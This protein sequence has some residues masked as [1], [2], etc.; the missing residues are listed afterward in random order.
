MATDRIDRFFQL[1]RLLDSH[2]EYDLS[3]LAQQHGVHPRTLQRDLERLRKLGVAE[4]GTGRIGSQLMQGGRGTKV[5]R[6]ADKNAVV[7]AFSLRISP[8]SC[9]PGYDCMVQ[10]TL[11]NVLDQAPTAVRRAVEEVFGPATPGANGPLPPGIRIDDHHDTP[12][13]PP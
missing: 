12:P 2:E 4:N 10:E 8:M 11:K 1:A 13:P 3:D 9:I 7:I 5:Y 6:L